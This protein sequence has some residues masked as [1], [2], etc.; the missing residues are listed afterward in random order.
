MEK[1]CFKCGERKLRS[2]F[3]KH[4]KMSDG[5]LGKCKTCTKRDSRERVAVLIHNPEWLQKER[6]RCRIKQENYRKLGLAHKT[7]S[8]TQKAWRDR[9]P[10][11]RAAHNAANNALR[12]GSI[13]R[14]TKCEGCGGSG[15]R[16]EKHHVDYSLKLDVK[17]LCPKCHGVTKRK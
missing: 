17:W 15:V 8:K 13:E 11:K 1:Q 6:E 14:K 5:F 16:L 3:Y 4:P 12:K 2:E 9:N 7:S 10:E